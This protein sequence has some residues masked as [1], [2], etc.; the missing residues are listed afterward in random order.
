MDVQP[1]PFQSQLARYRFE[2]YVLEVAIMTLEQGGVASR[3]DTCQFLP[4]TDSWS[5]PKYPARTAILPPDVDLVTELKAF[6]AANEPFLT[7]PDCWLGTWIN[8]Q[9]GHFYL[10]V[11]T[12]CADLD[13]A[14]RIAHAVS[15]RDGRQIVALYN[16]KRKE[17]VYL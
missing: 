9:T 14:R 4:P 13:E 12:A 5:F 1:M 2:K 10:D 16:A 17:T 15:A 3:P 8:P 6:I 11:A 7:E